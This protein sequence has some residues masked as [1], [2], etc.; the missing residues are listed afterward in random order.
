MVSKINRKEEKIREKLQFLDSCR[1]EERLSSLHYRILELSQSPQISDKYAA[2][3]KSVLPSPEDIFKH[4]LSNSD[5]IRKINALQNN[6]ESEYK[7]PNQSPIHRT[8]N[9]NFDPFI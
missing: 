7:A 9:P 6:T 3:K 1:Y 4:T 5:Q 2:Q 8:T